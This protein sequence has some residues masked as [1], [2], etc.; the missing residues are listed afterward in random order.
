MIRAGLIAG[1][2]LASGSGHAETLF[3]ID[4]YDV[5]GVTSDL[6]GEPVVST[7]GDG[8]TFMST[9]AVATL[10]VFASLDVLGGFSVEREIARQGLIDA[11]STITAKTVDTNSFSYSGMT[12]G[13]DAFFRYTRMGATCEGVA[14]FGSFEIIYGA[15]AADIYSRTAEYMIEDFLIGACG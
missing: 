1:L 3:E 11:G 10:S 8:L 12:A 5:T 4:R 14:V 15:D 7:A 9:D 13:G 6:F 2:I